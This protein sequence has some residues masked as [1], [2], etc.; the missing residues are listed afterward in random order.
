MNTLQPPTRHRAT[1]R[2]ANKTG[3]LEAK[4]GRCHGR[5][6]PRLIKNTQYYIWSTDLAEYP[7]QEV[8]GTQGNIQIQTYHLCPLLECRLQSSRHPLSPSHFF[9][10]SP[11]RHPNGSAALEAQP[12]LLHREK[13][14]V[15]CIFP[16]LISEHGDRHTSYSYRPHLTV[17]GLAQWGLQ[18]LW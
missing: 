4:V 15:A 5:F 9:L 16:S 12:A 17:A 11:C 1:R 2:Q 14:K 18:G 6:L 3:S 10:M 8:R 13:N 7:P